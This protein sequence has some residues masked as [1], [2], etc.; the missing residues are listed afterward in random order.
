MAGKTVVIGDVHGDFPALLDL[1]QPFME[2][3]ISDLPYNILFLG[4]LVDRGNQGF[5]ILLLLAALK[6]KHPERIHVIRGNH[7]VC[8]LP[9]A[10]T[11]PSPSPDSLIWPIGASAAVH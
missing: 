10:A 2:H 8:T 7:E 11:G 9:A 6:A 3:L 1:L 4:D 5:L